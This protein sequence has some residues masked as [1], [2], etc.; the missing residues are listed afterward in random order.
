MMQQGNPAGLGAL[1]NQMRP[2]MQTQKGAIPPGLQALMQAQQV[3]R[4]QANPTTPQGT[5][6]V[7]GQTEQAIA[8]QMQPPAPQQMPQQPQMQGQIGRAHV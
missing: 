6:T 1:I 5:P 3:L 2:N 7:A 8:Q 4:S